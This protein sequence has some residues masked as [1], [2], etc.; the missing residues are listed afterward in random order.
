MVVSFP[1]MKEQYE[2]VSDSMLKRYFRLALPVF[3]VCLIV[4]L[5]GKLNL[6]VNAEAAGI[7][8]SPWLG[9]YYQTMPGFLQIFVSA[10]ISIW[11]IG[12][13]TFSTAFWMLSTLFYG[14]YLA[15][16]LSILSWKKE[17]RILWVYAGISLVFLYMNSMMLCFSIGVI[18]AFCLFHRRELLCGLGQKRDTVIGIVLLLLGIFFGGYPTYVQPTNVYRYFAFL[19]NWF[20]V[21]QVMH[22]LGAAFL[23]LGCFR[24]QPV[25]HVLELRPLQHLGEIS[26]SLYIVHIPLLFSAFMKLFEVLYGQTGQYSFSA[27]VSYLISLIFL[28]LFSTGYYR[29]I[30]KNCGKITEKL[31]Y[32]FL[33]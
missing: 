9:K 33:K 23:L 20:T 26:Y 30:E 1:A 21:S 24:L 7:T 29:T 8:G 2:K 6:F 13:N 11:F 31:I 16:V 32:S 15:Y 18:L 25:K 14:S 3:F 10:F 27:A 5:M 22:I 17:K 19:G 4:Y 28:V 12:D